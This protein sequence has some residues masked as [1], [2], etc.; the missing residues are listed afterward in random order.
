MYRAR[1]IENVF[2]D[3]AAQVVLEGRMTVAEIRT[4]LK[5]DDEAKV[6][7]NGVELGPSAVPDDGLLTIRLV[8]GTFTTA[9]AVIGLVVAVSA[10]VVGVVAL[11]NLDSTRFPDMKALQASSSLR[12]SSNAARK[13]GR[14]PLLLGRHRVYPDA[15]ALP[16]SSYKDDDQYLHQLFCFGYSDVSVDF[17]TL[18]IGETLVSGYDGCTCCDGTG[19]IYPSRVVENVYSIQLKNDGAAMPVV[20][21]TASGC[22]AIQVGIMAPNGLYR[23]EGEARKAVSVGLKIEWRIPDGQWAVAVDESITGDL[24]HV[25]RTYSISPGGSSDGVYEVRV[26]RTTGESDSLQVCDKVYLDV[27]RSFVGAS[28]FTSPVYADGLRLVALKTK[29]TDQLN[30]V[31]DGLNAVCTLKARTWDGVGT[32]A[33]HW[34]RDAT[35]NPASAILYLLTSSDANPEP[36]EDGL[37]DWA[38]FEE[39]HS[40]CEGNGFHCD[41]WITGEFT[42]MQLC[43]YIASSNLAELVVGCDS[44]GIRIEKAQSGVV[45]LFTPR[46]AWG[47]GMTRSFESRPSSLVV[48]FLDESKGYVEV[49]RRV[50]VDDYGAISFDTVSQSDSD[51]LRID[52][53]GVTSANHAARLGAQKLKLL[54]SQTRTY[55]WK[56]DIEGIVSLPGDVVL[57]ENDNFLLGLGE[58]RIKEVVREGTSTTGVVLDSKVRMLSEG[59]YGVT[60]RTSSGVFTSIPV[61]TEEGEVFALRFKGD[62]PSGMGLSVGDLVSFGEYRKEAHRVLITEMTPDQNRSCSFK[63]VDYVEDA[64]SPEP[65]VPSFDSG[66]S[67]YP[68]DGGSIGASFGWS[69]PRYEIHGTQGKDGED[70][71]SFTVVIESSNG[72]VF[73]PGDISTTLTC[74]VYLNT[75]EVTEDIPESKFNWKRRTKDELGDEKWSTSSKA[76]GHRSVDITSADCNGRTVFGCEVDLPEI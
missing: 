30:G 45:Q 68:D 8:P 37:I 44:I 58:G 55:S 57:I 9:M 71:L 59:S 24:D 65:S 50:T 27:I 16:F 47:F 32:G 74:R 43:G 19:D 70:G 53:F 29:A 3:H 17:S 72:D 66:L 22:H 5:L 41:A 14:L 18:K 13:G 35:R 64:Y 63:A 10:V 23:Y 67:R 34:Y 52:S 15:A 40:F 69:V 56:S 48:G 60:V 31:V 61:E 46:N 20:R 7:Q 21:A 75:A 36:V 62:P 2:E 42:V 73:R 26:S 11:S 6:F 51:S 38:S 4:Y 25:R 49:E 76:V 28:G 12:G 54:H 33:S 39:F 1:I